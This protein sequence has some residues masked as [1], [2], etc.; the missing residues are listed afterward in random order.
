MTSLFSSNNQVKYLNIIYNDEVYTGNI[1]NLFDNKEFNSLSV[2]TFVSSIK[3]FF[4]KVND[5]DKI[6]LLLGIEDGENAQK[7]LFD[8]NYTSSFFSNLDKKTLI[9]ILNND[10]SIRFTSTGTTIHSK[11]YILKNLKTNNTRVIFGSA[12]FSTKAFGGDRQFEELVVY[13]SLYNSKIVD[14]FL[15]RYEDIKK[16]TNDFIPDII[17]KKAKDEEKIII[18]NAEDSLDILQD[19]LKNAQI[20]VVL[21]E[22]L[23]KNIESTKKVIVNQEENLK[24]E[25]KSI[26]QTKTVI[27]IVTKATK[28]ITTF[29]TPAQFIKNK[30]QL[31]T[32]VLKPQT[33]IKEFKDS[34]MNLVYSPL[35]NHFYIKS[36][37]SEDNTLEQFTKEC[38]K[39]IIK[40][41][42]ELLDKFINVYTKYTMNK[43]EATKKRIFEAILY[44]FTSPCIWKIRENI[45]WQQ[46]RDESKSAVP[47]FMLIA[48]QSQSGKTHLLKFISQIMGNLGNYY[49]FSKSS[50]LSSMSEINPQTIY[51]FFEEENLMPIFIDEIIKDYFS[52]N[53]SSTSS[54]MGEGF[55]KKLTNA[56]DG[57][58]PCM[59]ASSNTDFSA[60]SQVMRRIYYIQ[61]NNPFDVSKKS[62][63]DDIFTTL[64]HDFG[65]DLYRD[66]LFK[67]E[68]KLNSGYEIDTNDI[69]K[70]SRE[71]FK[72]YFKI[73]DMPIPSYFSEERIDDYYIRGQQMWRDLYDMKYDGFK[74]DKKTNTILLNDEIVFGIKLNSNGTK[75]ELLQYLPIG[76]LVED[77]GIVK[78]NHKNFFDFIKQNSRNLGFFQKIFS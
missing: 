25:L 28:G 54:Y 74:E 51:N 64:L 3:Y 13:D 68:Q 24:K 37:E 4:N 35:E 15:Q 19:R 65:N 40:E 38:D 44:A 50:K 23:S 34:R 59:I 71:V 7:F 27:E 2:C 1:E 77:K 78:L 9:K 49:H 45:M 33:I 76:V 30:E 48:G 75:K 47:L 63:M 52:S 8:P 57:K 39:T 17:R 12:N 6:E 21:P 46:G 73:L 62:E 66:F 56:K 41:K 18:L 32:K 60:N 26:E 43:E 67:L 22:D 16:H 11:I 10:V 61:L 29:I 20:G 36:E 55:I 42:L 58:Y 31:I 69:L 5:F 70:P 72:E 53:S 14:I